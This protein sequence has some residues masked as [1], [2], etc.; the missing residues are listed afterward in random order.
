MGKK[1]TKCIVCGGESFAKYC[2][3]VVRCTECGLVVATELPTPQEIDKLYQEDYFFGQE[4]FDYAADRPALEHNFR[5]RI[6][7]LDHLLGKNKDVVEVGCAYGYFL[8]LIKDRVTSHL[9]FDVSQEGV[10]FAKKELGLR[11]T[12]DDFMTYKFK[13]DSVDSVFMWDVIEH[14]SYP[15]DYIKKVHNILKP[16]G[17]VAMT[18]GDIGKF[19]PRLRGSKWRMIHPPTHVY[20]F[21]GTTLMRLLQQNGFEVESIKYN[22]V[23]R[24]VGSV[25]NQII[26]NRK[27]QKK[28]TALFEKGYRLAQKVRATELNIPVNTFDIM[29]VVARKR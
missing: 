17:Y 4:Y 12:T 2:K 21:T 5:K 11:A 28:S 13:K 8:N 23:S 14:L 1:V 19:L 27:A 20:Y 9:G 25:M 18:T 22:S 16:G 7:A 15:E 6:K 24:N 3:D 10:D 29:E 26:N